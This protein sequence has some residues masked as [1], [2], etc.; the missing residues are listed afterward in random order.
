MKMNL[1]EIQNVEML[2]A[3]A[4]FERE[5]AQKKQTRV[6]TI[7]RDPTLI[8]AA[9]NSLSSDFVA[10]FYREDLENMAKHFQQS[11]LTSKLVLSNYSF[12]LV[13]FS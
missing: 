8:D 13:L 6:E 3:V 5:V 7:L 2:K 1:S 12:K 4:I 9:V 11:S 10:E